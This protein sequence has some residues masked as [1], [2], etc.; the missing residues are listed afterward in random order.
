M[1][2][3]S[4]ASA[5]FPEYFHARVDEFVPHNRETNLRSPHFEDTMY[6]QAELGR[7]V[8]QKVEWFRGGLVCKARRL[9]VSLKSRLES[10][11]NTYTLHPTFYTLHPTPYTLH[12]TRYT[13]HPRPYT[14]HPTPYT[15]RF[16]PLHPLPSPFSPEPTLHMKCWIPIRS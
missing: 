11:K 16:C 14:P 3:S 6:R 1:R 2:P 10:K 13:Q 9:G 5:G 7:G 12:P 8:L 15:T 4:S